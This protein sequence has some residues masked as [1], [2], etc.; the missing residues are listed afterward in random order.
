MK[1]D[2][3]DLLILAELYSSDGEVTTSDMAKELYDVEDRDALQKYDSRVRGKLKKLVDYGLIVKET[4]GKT[5]MYMVNPDAV[6]VAEG[7]VDANPLRGEEER[8]EFELEDIVFARNGDY[9]FMYGVLPI[10]DLME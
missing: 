6:T 9:V 2:R 3:Y 7:V 5:S 10:E 8:R 4:K 1:I